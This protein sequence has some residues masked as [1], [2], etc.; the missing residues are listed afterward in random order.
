MG[1]TRSLAILVLVVGAVLLLGFATSGADE[2]TD[3]IL[4]ALLA[5]HNRERARERKPPLRLSRKLCDSARLHAR[6]MAEHH[7]MEH[8]GSDGSTVA[9][10]VK[11]Q[12][13][14][15]LNVGENIAKGQK[16]VE[17]VMTTWM[18]SPRHH[19][20][21]MNERF[22]EMGAGFVPDDKGQIYWCVNF[23]RPIPRLDPDR[24][25]QDVV[26]QINAD[27]ATRQQPALKVAPQ[28]RQAAAEISATL[29]AKK[30]LEA[31]GDP[32]QT[33]KA[34]GYRWKEAALRLNAGAPTP[35]DAARSLLGKDHD[36][37]DKFGEI[38]VGYAS[39]SDGT[40]YWCA[41]F[42]TPP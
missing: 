16:T 37:L 12:G 28:L 21:I 34:Q 5:S 8:E 11:R 36:Q 22:T 19:A 29:A 30:S 4:A 6:D 35:A 25:A 17:E 40:P 33:I 7:R 13:Y 18:N 1:K 41:I 20:N 10:R 38:G 9:D 2:R 15:Y 24:A 32:F 14:V 3:R 39:A 31:A 26:R 27:R 42:A 23:G